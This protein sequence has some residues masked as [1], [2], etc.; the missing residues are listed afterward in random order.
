MVTALLLEWLLLG[1]LVREPPNTGSNDE[2]IY[3]VKS[4][5]VMKEGERTLNSRVGRK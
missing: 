3:K 4:F 1:S 2:N 5:I